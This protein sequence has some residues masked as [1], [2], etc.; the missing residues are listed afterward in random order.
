MQTL[1]ELPQYILSDPTRLRQILINVVGNAIKFTDKGSVDV[2][3]TY[4]PKTE[5]LSHGTLEFIVADSGI[6]ISP[7]QINKL[8]QPFVQA[9]ESMTRKFGGTGLGLFLS[10]KL[11]RLLG[12]DL[13]L[14]SSHPGKGSQ[15]A[16]ALEV[17]VVEMIADEAEE[18][19][20]KRLN[21]VDAI[22]SSKTLAD[23]S[24]RH[25]RVLIVDDAADN[26]TIVSIYLDKM[27]LDYEV[28]E[29]GMQGVDKALKEKFDVI[30]MDIQMP[31]LDGFEAVQLLR[32]RN[33]SGPIIALTAHAMKGDKEKCLMRGFNDYLSKPLSKDSL[34]QTI[35]K[36]I[37]YQETLLH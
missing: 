29:N 7:L 28:A 22:N 36:Y 11:A 32:D 15:F 3:V 34:R 4:K 16:I 26:R 33:Y 8:F 31:E 23:S 35:D 9:D 13:S 12:G 5:D 6:G 1:P 19:S 18:A 17:Q 20:V 21:N 14:K 10:R 2:T 25:G 30:L 37:D 27:G 24:H